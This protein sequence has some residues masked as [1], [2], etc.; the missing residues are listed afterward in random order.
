MEPRLRSHQ[1]WRHAPPLGTAR[2]SQ[3]GKEREVVK[4]AVERE[5]R[6]LA[7]PDLASHG[8]EILVHGI[9]VESGERAPV[10]RRALPCEVLLPREESC[11]GLVFKK[12]EEGISFAV[13][14]RHLVPQTKAVVRELAESC[15]VYAA[16]LCSELPEQI[17][18][19][20]CV[21]PAE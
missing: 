5:V 4:E 10:E 9:V 7:R 11:T 21:Y 15:G 20:G 1:P 16:G 14:A 18:G 8:A 19:A 3:S 13:L 12:R 6:R 17:S 2:L